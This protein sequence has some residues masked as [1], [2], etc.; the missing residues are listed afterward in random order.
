[1]EYIAT[2][3]KVCCWNTLRVFLMREERTNHMALFKAS[4]AERDN[5]SPT[6]LLPKC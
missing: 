5:Y 3:C 4:G 2:V 1:M 6:N